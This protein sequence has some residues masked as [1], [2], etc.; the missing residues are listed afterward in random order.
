MKPIDLNVVT[1]RTMVG[2]DPNTGGSEA[3]HVSGGWIYLAV[4]LV[5]TLL[6]FFM[7]G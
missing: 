3:I 2:T 7:A 1:N 6:V 4:S 5:T